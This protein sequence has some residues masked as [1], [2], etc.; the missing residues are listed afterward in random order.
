[1]TK[2]DKEIKIGRERK[3]K[4]KLEKGMETKMNRQKEIKADEK[5]KKTRR[6]TEVKKIYLKKKL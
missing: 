5:K 1:M 2:R 4:R 3:G 6:G